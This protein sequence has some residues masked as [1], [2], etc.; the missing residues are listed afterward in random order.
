MLQIHDSTEILCRKFEIGSRWQNYKILCYLNSMKLWNICKNTRSIWTWCFKTFFFFYVRCYF[1]HI[2]NKLSAICC[3]VQSRIY[4]SAFDAFSQDKS[5]WLIVL[6]HVSETWILACIILSILF[7]MH[8]AHIFLKRYE[9]NKW[10]VSQ[11]T[12]HCDVRKNY[13][14]WTSK[15][16]K[17]RDMLVI[18][19]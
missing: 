9:Q 15:L 4:Q 17:T 10:R 2:K 1:T 6:F 7:A 13:I 12:L 5:C 8:L 18:W 11:S 3:F 19:P 16:T 14:I